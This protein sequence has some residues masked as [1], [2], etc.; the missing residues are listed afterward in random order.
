MNI[1]SQFSYNFI[2][3][4]VLYSQS[5]IPIHKYVNVKQTYIFK[6]FKTDKKH[7]Q[8]YKFVRIKKSSIL[9]L[10]SIF[11][12]TYS[13]ISHITKYNTR[14][15]SKNVCMDLHKSFINPV[16]ILCFFILK[17]TNQGLREPN[18]T[19]HCNQFSYRT[20]SNYKTII[21]YFL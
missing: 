5:K 13:K 6:C 16:L 12:N 2:S 20:N 11:I 14:K 8:G 7:K 15:N 17:F 10:R 19:L 4:Y 18:T 9:K 3:H 1:Q 21:L